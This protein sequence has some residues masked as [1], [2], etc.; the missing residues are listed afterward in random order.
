MKW[1]SERPRGAVAYVSFGSLAELEAEKINGRTGLG[2]EEE[3]HLLHT[4]C[5]W[6]EKKTATK[7]PKG[8]AEEIWEK[9]FVVA[10]CPQ[11]EVLAH[12]AVGVS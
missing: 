12:E 4:S 7:L 3:Q 6:S 2:F 11:L 10:W 9:G 1:L 8:L 5:G